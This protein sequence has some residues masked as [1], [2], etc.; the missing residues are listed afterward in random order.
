MSTRFQIRSFRRFAIQCPIYYSNDKFHGK[1]TA[2]NL[3]LNG[4]RVDGTH[5]VEPGMAFTL[6]IFLPGRVRTV[7]VDR[8]AVRWSRGHEFGIELVTK[9]NEQQVVLKDFV[10]LLI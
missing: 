8:A 5:P 3:S 1:G 4:W 9:K 7:F 10:D 6:C 2:W